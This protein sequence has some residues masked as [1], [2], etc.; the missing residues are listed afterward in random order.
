MLDQHNNAFFPETAISTEQYVFQPLSDTWTLSRNA[1]IRLVPVA[2]LVTPDFLKSFRWSIYQLAIKFSPS[3][4]RNTT[5]HFLNYCRFTYATTGHELSEIKLVDALN[6]QNSLTGDRKWLMQ[7]LK[8]V[9]IRIGRSGLLGIESKALDFFK[10]TRFES[11]VT[12]QAVRT[13]DASKGALTALEI[14]ALDACSIAAFEDGRITLEEYALFSISRALGSRPIQITDLKRCDFQTFSDPNEYRRFVLNLPRRKQR[15]GDERFRGDFRVYQLTRNVGEILQEY[16]RQS[17]IRI[18]EEIPDCTQA[19][20]SQFPMFPYWGQLQ[21]ASKEGNARSLI[22]HGDAFHRTASRVSVKICAIADSCAAPSERTG[23]L[24]VF[25]TRFRRTVGT[26]AAAEGASELEIACLLDQ[27]NS[28]S[29]KIYTE[30]VLENA[31]A[32]DKAVSFQLAPLAQAFA[33][34]LVRS[35]RQA[36]RGEDVES[37]VRIDTGEP[38]GS[39]GNYSFCSTS[40]PIGCYTCRHFQ[41]WRD[42]PHEQLLEHLVARRAEV[43]RTTGDMSIA[44]ATDRSIFAVAEVVKLCAGERPPTPPAA[45]VSETQAVETSNG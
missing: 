10:S 34:T 44:A 22:G 28:T 17:E 30:N 5:D 35:E 23:V 6:F 21:R 37:R 8:I 26:R 1:K 14:E 12:G 7:Y 25:P 11:N 4:A 36:R 15:N 3:H 20:L 40:V 19:E 42:A 41:P 33:G 24:D 9:S 43:L 32:I 39:C 2:G 27:T 38:V 18:L 16:L 29:A 13:K 45:A 31:L